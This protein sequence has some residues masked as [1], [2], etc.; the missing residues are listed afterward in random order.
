MKEIRSHWSLRCCFSGHS[1]LIPIPDSEFLLIKSR[2]MH[3]LFI[4]S[5]STWETLQHHQRVCHV[6]NQEVRTMTRTVTVRPA[7]RN[8]K[9]ILTKSFNST[10]KPRKWQMLLNSHYCLENLWKKRERQ[11]PSRVSTLS[12]LSVFE[13]AFSHLYFILQ[14]K[15]TL[16]AFCARCKMLMWDLTRDLVAW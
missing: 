16:V 4:F 13:Q 7:L 9:I 12:W 14:D 5:L 6:K 8:Q 15:V 2:E 3:H 11:A 1:V 10:S